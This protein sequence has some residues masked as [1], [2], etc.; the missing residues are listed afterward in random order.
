MWG[1]AYRAAKVAPGA[2]AQ[3]CGPNSPPGDNDPARAQPSHTDLAPFHQEHGSRPDWRS[4][5][6]PA[7]CHPVSLTTAATAVQAVIGL[8]QPVRG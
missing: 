8:A 5:R 6:Q 1:S 7:Q 2:A 3:S 4:H